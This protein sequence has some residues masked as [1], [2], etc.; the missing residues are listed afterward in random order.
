MKNIISHRSFISRLSR[1]TGVRSV[2]AFAVL[3]SIAASLPAPAQSYSVLYAFHGGTDG[4]SPNGALVRDAA[5]DLFGTTANGG[6]QLCNIAYGVGCGT[7]FKVDAAGVETILHSFGGKADGFYPLSGVS[8]SGACTLYGSAELG[9]DLRCN[10]PIGCG[11]IFKLD[12]RTLGFSVLHTF[13]GS[14]DGFYPGALRNDAADNIYGLTSG[15]GA[16][17]PTC[18]KGC[19]TVFKVDAT[20]VETVL[21]NFTG[22]ADGGDPATALGGGLVRD[23]GGNLY[24]TAAVGGQ[25]PCVSGGTYGCGVVFKVQPDGVETVLHAFTGTDGEDPSG[26]LIPSASGSAFYG[27]TAFGGTYGRGT[28]FKVDVQGNYRVL[29]N[30]T[31]G[32]DGANPFYNLVRDAAGNLYGVNSGSS[33]SRGAV[34][35][36]DPT[37]VLSVLYNFTGGADGGVPFGAL[38]LDAAGNLYGVTGAGGD[39]TCNPPNGCGVVFKIAP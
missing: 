25:I 24:G 11:L 21:Y 6:K 13:T 5:G 14:P 2:L 12:T 16:P 4:A 7:V 28:V 32:A 15:G 8:G 1:I 17:S 10:S 3:F 26:G 23:S 18:P 33:S 19:G 20:G 38:I 9:G 29:Y 37:G 22:G 30:F 34:F 31:G 27:T 35:K 39:L 36:L